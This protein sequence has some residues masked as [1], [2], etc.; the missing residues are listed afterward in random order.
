M[1]SV[2]TNS[3]NP[4]LSC[5]N[6]TTPFRRTC[7]YSECG[8]PIGTEYTLTTALAC[9]LGLSPLVCIQCLDRAQQASASCTDEDYADVPCRMVLQ[10]RNS[11]NLSVQSSLPRGCTL[12]VAWRSLY[13][14]YKFCCSFYTA[15]SGQC[16][17]R[18]ASTLIVLRAP[19]AD[20]SARVGKF[21]RLQLGCH[22]DMVS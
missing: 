14:Q 13:N 9:T 7:G 19:G 6:R 22:S 12:A 3:N 1:N 11:T 4:S 21:L 5:S 8:Q 2:A 10:E 15:S 17:W 20:Y 18:Q 16:S